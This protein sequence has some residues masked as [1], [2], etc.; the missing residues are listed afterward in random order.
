M[1]KKRRG[2][3]GSRYFLNFEREF[4]S[5]IQVDPYRNFRIV[6][7]LYEEAK[8][9]RIFPLKDPLDGIDVDIRIAKVV[10]SISESAGEDSP[11][12]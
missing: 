12:S 4:E 1:K 10:N 9:F 5:G 2:G 6:E 11:H 8:A 7:A 3:K